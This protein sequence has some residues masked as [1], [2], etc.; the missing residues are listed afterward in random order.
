VFCKSVPKDVIPAILTAGDVFVL[1][2]LHEGSNNA[3]V[4]AMASGLP[5]ISSDIPEVREQVNEELAVLVDPLSIDQIRE[6]IISLKNDKNRL[7]VMSEA[8]LK[9]SKNFDIKLRAKRII[10]F[11]NEQMIN[12]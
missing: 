3:I 9:N 2:T 7:N 5:I 8:S 11:I 12:Q 1:P 10:N 4:E 6:A